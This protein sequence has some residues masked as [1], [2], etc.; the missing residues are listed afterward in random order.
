MKTILLALGIVAMSAV[1]SM[2]APQD[3]PYLCNEA[4]GHLVDSQ[5]C[6]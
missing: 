5:I 3:N 4:D 1:S 2:A 6:R